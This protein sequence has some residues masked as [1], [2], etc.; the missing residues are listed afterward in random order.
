[1]RPTRVYSLTLIISLFSFILVS[2]CKKSN[3]GGGNSISGTV[4]TTNVSGGTTQGAYSAY[5]GMFLLA[6]YSV[7]GKDTTGFILNIPSVFAKVGK[8]F[9]SDSTYLEVV[10]GASG[11]KTYDASYGSGHASVTVNQLDTVGHKINGIF[12]ATAYNVNSSNDSVVI[13]NGKF[14]S[15]YTVQ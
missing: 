8:A 6:S 15:S 4:G 11:G 13:T 9:T 3:S 2:S 10:Y 14:S 5:A 12:T 7:Q 1:M